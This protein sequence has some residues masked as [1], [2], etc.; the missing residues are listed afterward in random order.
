M[1]D[2]RYDQNELAAILR[3][4]A[5]AQANETSG[6]SQPDGL[7]LGEIE[8]VASEVG[9]DPKFI[10]GAADNLHQVPTTQGFRLG[11]TPSQVI[12]ERNIDGNLDDPGWEDVV[13]DLRATF[14]SEGTI[15]QVGSSREWV[16]TT[17]TR[18]VHLSATP[19]NGR[20]RYR[21]SLRQT[22]GVI[23]AWTALAV[24]GLLSSIL[25]GVATDKAGGSA[26]VVLPVILATLLTVALIV[27]TALARWHAKNLDNIEGLLHRVE[28]LTGSA[29]VLPSTI[30]SQKAEEVSV[31][32]NDR[33]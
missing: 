19:K 14:G 29:E 33:V 10:R 1:P 11:G 32:L 5:E 18:T 31:R 24:G 9:I 28:A 7:T 16:G 13:A 21:L 2:R 27:H 12:I 22:G 26:L 3:S 17:D 6:A 30:P 8:R 20:T 25:I 4:A 23:L 15:S